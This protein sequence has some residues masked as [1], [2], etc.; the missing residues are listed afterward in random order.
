LAEA[1][2]LYVDEG[3]LQRGA[4]VVRPLAKGELVPLAA[5]G[6]AKDVTGTTIVLSLTSPL[7]A[8]SSVGAVVDL[9]AAAQL[10][11]NSFGPPVVIVPRAQIAR[12]IEASGIGSSSQNV[13]VEVVIP[14]S[15]VALLLQAQANGDAI[16]LVP[17]TA[18][19]SGITS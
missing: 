14:R 6:S 8:A 1:S 16:S 13:N 19:E 18:G 10:G 11:Q 15:K 4:V 9:W 12:I 17:T 5:V 2:A 3:A 7:A